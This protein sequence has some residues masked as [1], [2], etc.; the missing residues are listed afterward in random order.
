MDSSLRAAAPRTS[1]GAALRD[2]RGATP[3]E[4]GDDPW[5]P[6]VIADP[7]PALARLRGAPLAKVQFDILCRGML[8]DLPTMQL[9]VEPRWKPRFILRGLSARPVRT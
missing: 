5:D 3:S 8:S 6:A 4:L 7:Y 1:T 9:V 2:N